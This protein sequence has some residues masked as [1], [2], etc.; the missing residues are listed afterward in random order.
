MLLIF[1]YTKHHNYIVSKIIAN[2]Y[3][4]NEFVLQID[5]CTN[6]QNVV[7]K[8]IYD[9][10]NIFIWFYCRILLLIG[11]KIDILLPHPEQLLSNLFFYSD[12]IR[13]RYIYEDGLMNYV[14]VKLTGLILRR[15]NKRKKLSYILFYK[16]NLVNGYLS[17]CEDKKIKGIFV[18]YPEL[19]YKSYAHGTLNKITIEGE[20]Y[21]GGS[22]SVLFIDQDIES[23]Y[24]Y[25]IANSLRLKLYNSLSNQELVYVK[26]HHDYFSKP[27]SQIKQPHNFTEINESLRSLTAE[28]IVG[29]IKPNL[30]V[31]FFSSALMNIATR[32]QGIKCYCC[33]PESHIVNCY[34]GRQPLS[35]LLSKFGVS[36]I[37]ELNN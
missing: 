29:I 12:N 17:G 36:C 1:K 10:K 33:L 37:D 27:S 25:E 13:N 11:C 26:R 23:Y 21:S 19:I 14:D 32:Y 7:S 15:A 6:R 2:G 18:Q 22:E 9:V 35:Y 34:L 30:V 8:L 28:D 16:Y 3:F 4:K 31:G 20:S 5:T 24:G